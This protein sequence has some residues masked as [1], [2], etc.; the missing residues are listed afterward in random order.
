MARLTGIFAAASAALAAALV[1]L[2]GPARAAAPAATPAPVGC[3]TAVGRAPKL[4]SVRTALVKVG[5]TPFGV[6][7]DRSWAF[8]S[9]ITRLYVLRTTAFTPRLV[10]SVATPDGVVGDTTTPGGRYVLAAVN[11]G[12][13]VFSAA[14]AESGHGRALLGTLTSPKGQGGIEVAV[15]GDGRYAFVSLEY[16]DQVAVFNLSRALHHG[17]GKADL[18]GTIPA[19]EAPVGLAFSP[20]GRWL[21]STS[22]VAPHHGGQGVLKVISVARAER[23]P[24]RSVVATVNAGCGPVRVITSGG[25]SVVWVTARESD[26]L[27]AFSAARLRTA[28]RR[29]LLA[30]VRVGEAPVGLILA[31]RGT[32]IIVADSNRF[33]RRGATASLA[34]VGVPAAL[35]GRPA[36]LGYIR[37][38][39]FPRQLALE[40]GGRTLLVTNFGSDQVEA[41]SL[42]RLG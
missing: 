19:A 35:A 23:D 17:F 7:T 27:L 32:R 6:V 31:G 30:R 41:V 34:V 9:A 22:E 1:A 12:A 38:G 2:P 29:A 13:Q 16:S 5:Q 14:R 20:D 26:S 8:V 10:R 11:N 28:P 40:P 18:V 3:S 4:T 37:S 36:L 24:A 39:R 25:G 21:Y 33:G 15:T 42:A